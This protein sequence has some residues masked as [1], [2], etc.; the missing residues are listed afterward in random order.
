M[1]TIE[2]LSNDY[3]VECIYD[4]ICVSV[5]NGQYKQA[6]ELAKEAKETL[7]YSYSDVRDATQNYPEHEDKIIEIFFEN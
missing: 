2:E 7:N 1:K 4:Y 5:I 3:E 6:R